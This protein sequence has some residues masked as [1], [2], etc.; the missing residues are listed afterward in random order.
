MN[1]FP[2]TYPYVYNHDTSSPI[3]TDYVT[4]DPQVS[5]QTAIQAIHDSLTRQASILDFYGRLAHVA[6][7]PQQRVLIDQAV[8]S[9]NT[10]FSQFSDFYRS[11]TGLPPSYLVERTTIHS[12]SEGVEM[13]FGAGLEGSVY[14]RQLASLAPYPYFQHLFL[15]ASTAERENAER[16]ASLD[17]ERATDQGGKPYVVNIETVTEQNNAYRTAI[18][19]G[20]HLQV[21]VMSIRVGEDIGLEVHPTT[22]QFIRIEEGEGLVQMGDQRD[23]LDFQMKA[24]ED[25]AIMIPAGKWHNITNTG[26]EPLKIYAIYAPP[27]HPFGAVQETRETATEEV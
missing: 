15:N 10:Q 1:Q 27:E 7:S 23:Q 24:S 4:S 22:D 20:K 21:T 11:L 9:A 16:F 12:Y 5:V 25:Y 8:D 3:Y 26:D 13:A 17:E 2:H 6:P 14:Y 19:T 18:W